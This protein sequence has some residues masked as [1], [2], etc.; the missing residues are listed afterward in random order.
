MTKIS[1]IQKFRSHVMQFLDAL[2]I[3]G[4]FALLPSFHY[5]LFSLINKYFETS[6]NPG[7]LEVCATYVVMLTIPLILEKTGFYSE[8][9][10]Q[11]VLKA[12]GQVFIG[13]II[14]GIFMAGFPLFFKGVGWEDFFLKRFIVCFLIGGLIFCRYLLTHFIQ[15]KKD[16]KPH[17]HE[18]LLFVGNEADLKKYW[19]E[20]SPEDKLDYH[21]VAIF[22]P[23]QRK[24]GEFVHVLDE[25]AVSRVLFFA[26]GIE[27]DRLNNIL[28]ICELQ[29]IELWLPPNFLTTKIARAQIDVFAHQKMLVFRSTPTE[30]TSLFIKC[31][32]DKV[33][34]S[35]ILFCS[36]P[37]WIFAILSI[38]ISDPGPIFFK[39][40]R[41]GR[42]GKEFDMWKFR[43]MKVGADKILDQ[44]KEEY[45]NNMSGPIFKLENDPRI[46]KMG[47]MMRKFSI[48][49]LPQ[50]INV[51]KGDMSLVGPRPL[52]V[53][54]V[55]AFESLE[56]KRRHSMKP[57][58]TCYWQIEGRS[59]ITD[60]N[61]LVKLDF[62]YIDNWSLLLDIKLLLRTIP[63]V[64]F[65]RGAK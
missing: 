3:V 41:T 23:N 35:F 27:L 4:L 13:V 21:V 63:A 22:D 14:L 60:F 34:G 19:E 12:L 44:I 39:Q 25:F 32:M 33:V 36:L 37:A 1:E 50:L 17:A 29:G 28:E 62:K 43:T 47:R 57:G 30:Y 52:P 55:K 20:M 26:E 2:L 7:I 53:Y 18:R 10:R 24:R 65:G 9:S 45:G 42:Y 8:K 38:K 59:N 11:S 46:F 15:W 5:R 58:L 54:E 40:K 6:I 16:K 48:D 56:A 61:E 51:I 49:E 31:C 64:L